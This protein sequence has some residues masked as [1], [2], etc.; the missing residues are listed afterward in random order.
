M[1][2]VY[3]NPRIVAGGPATG[4]AFKCE[5]KPIDKTDYKRPVT[6]AQLAQV[7]DVFPQGVCDYTKKGVMQHPVSGTWL[8]YPSSS[9]ATTR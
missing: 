8:T 2:P 7:R 1:F 9:A 3:A 5:L 4:D 6:D